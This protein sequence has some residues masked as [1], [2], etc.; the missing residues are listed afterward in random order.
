MTEFGFDGIAERRAVRR[1]RWRQRAAQACRV[2]G[3][4]GSRP[5]AVE[6]PGAQ[7]ATHCFWVEYDLCSACAAGARAGGE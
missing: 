4:T 3:C 7:A 6:L 1:D 5:C 2:C